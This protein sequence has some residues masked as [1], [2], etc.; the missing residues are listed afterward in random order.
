MHHE[1]DELLIQRD[2]VPDGEIT[3][4]FRMGPSVSIFSAVFFLT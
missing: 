3:F 4:Q 2:S 1:E